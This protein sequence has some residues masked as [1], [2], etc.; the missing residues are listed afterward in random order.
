VCAS[1]LAELGL[2][3]P[4]RRRLYA[5]AV[6]VFAA[7]AAGG[8]EL[9][10]SRGFIDEPRTA[11]NRCGAFVFEVAKF[12]GGATGR[13]PRRSWTF[14]SKNSPELPPIST[15]GDV[16]SAAT[17]WFSRGAG[18]CDAAHLTLLARAGRPRPADAR[19]TVGPWSPLPG[20][21]PRVPARP[22][23]LRRG[24][25]ATSSGV[26]AR[27]PQTGHALGRGRPIARRGGAPPPFVHGGARRSSPNGR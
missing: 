15:F 14:G 10:R 7:H 3:A 8:I 18:G 26:G 12:E 27:L 16:W 5:I 22:M 17:T 25:G 23:R 20:G 24:H 6:R 11:A 13:D 1:Q 9:R 2:A 4:D 19:S 21:V